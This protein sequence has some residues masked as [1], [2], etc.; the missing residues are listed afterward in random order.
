M[1]KRL[2]ISIAYFAHPDSVH[3]CK[4]I[5]HFAKRYKVILFCPVNKKGQQ[6]I[7]LNKGIKVF[8]ILPMFSALNFVKRNKT[9]RQIKQILEQEKITILHSMYAIPNALYAD[10]VAENNHVITTRGSDILVEYS[11][12]FQNPKTIQERIS[13]PLMSLF[14]EKALHNSRIVTSTS[15]K[16]K[17]I[18]EKILHNKDKAYLV[19]TGVDTGKFDIVADNNKNTSNEFVIF[20]P[21]SMKPIYNIDL[22]VKAVAHFIENNNLEN[23]K[24]TLKIINDRTNDYTD[25]ILDL[26][27][28][29]PFLDFVK[30]LPRMNG[31]EMIKE[32]NNSNLVVMIPKSDGTP[33]SA[34]ET[35]LLKKPLILGALD[36]DEDLFNENTVW[37]AKDFSIKEISNT[38]KEVYNTPELAAQKIESAYTEAKQKANLDTS[39]ETLHNFYQEVIFENETSPV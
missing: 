17:K 8:S 31:D 21:R 18:I 23:K 1:K 3:D 2:P 37:K 24:I 9:K 19:R 14:L 32:Y 28:K 29:K 16:Q 6:F 4:W 10:L 7:W 25:Y 5:N 27:S 35:M 26:V 33:V 12:T 34:I 13:F 38:I 39:L 22:L 36:Y 15:L 11:N 30:V 20:S